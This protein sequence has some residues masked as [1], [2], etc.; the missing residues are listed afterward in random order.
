MKAYEIF[1][2]DESFEDV[3]NLYELNQHPG[4]VLTVEEPLYQALELLETYGNRTL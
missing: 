1:S 3:V 4:E 2:A